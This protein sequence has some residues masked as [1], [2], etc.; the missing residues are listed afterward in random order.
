MANRSGLAALRQIRRGQLRREA[1]DRA[2][3]ACADGWTAQSGTGILLATL[4]R[5]ERE[6]KIALDTRVADGRVAV[7]FRAVSP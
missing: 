1:S 6:G 2:Q 3:V 4:R 5:M 7:F